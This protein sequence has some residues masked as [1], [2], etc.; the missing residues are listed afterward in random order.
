MWP[1]VNNACLF[2]VL[3]TCCFIYLFNGWHFNFPL[4]FIRSHP[5]A[6]SFARAGM[7]VCIKDGYQFAFVIFYLISFYICVVFVD[8][9]HFFKMKTVKFF[10]NGENAVDYIFKFKIGL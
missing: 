9:I 1:I 2:I 4:R 6:I 5:S 10:G 3:L 7:E 8:V